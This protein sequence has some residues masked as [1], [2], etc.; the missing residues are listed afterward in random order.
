MFL[1]RIVIGQDVLLWA[2]QR[3]AVEVR[4]ALRI[5]F[6]GRWFIDEK[7][8]QVHQAVRS[9]FKCNRAAAGAC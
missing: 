2:C 6:A 5:W 9:L 1:Q 7:V 3:S 8:W 4:I